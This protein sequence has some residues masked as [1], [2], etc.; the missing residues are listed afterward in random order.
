LAKKAAKKSPR[1]IARKPVKETTR[2]K[3]PASQAPAR[4]PRA[5]AAAI[6][7]ET[8]HVAIRRG[9]PP[10]IFTIGYQGRDGDEVVSLLLEAGVEHLADIRAKPVS[11]NPEFRG[12]PLRR[13]C[14]AAGIEYGAWQSL[15]TPDPIRAR[16]KATRDYA[17]FHRDVRANAIESI[18]EAL[19][20][21]AA[22]ARTK[23][24]ALL[25]LERAHDEC[26]RADIAELLAD[27]IGAG[28]TAIQ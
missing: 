19:D 3:A 16:V 1:K 28:I 6:P 18:G 25:C 15:G 24:V 14:E 12:G 11:R 9:G 4:E 2:R 21:L 22:V 27:R 26:H 20:E 5:R 17:T 13:R 8:G 23:R 10:T 7:P